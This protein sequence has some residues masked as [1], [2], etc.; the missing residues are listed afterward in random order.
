MSDDLKVID[1]FGD[2]CPIPILK[3]EKQLEK[4]P[5]GGEFMLV[6]DHSCV[7]ESIKDIYNDRDVDITIDEVMN[8]VWEILFK[9]C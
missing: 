5:K 9:V 7:L 6:I 8:G 4:T 3:I 2:I 1:C